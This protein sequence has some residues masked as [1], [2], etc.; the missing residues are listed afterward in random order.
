MPPVLPIMRNNVVDVYPSIHLFSLITTRLSGSRKRRYAFLLAMVLNCEI[1]VVIYTSFRVLENE[2]YR[3]YP[4][5]AK[6]QTLF[7]PALALWQLN[8]DFLF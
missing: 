3:K 5:D 1:R 4:S 6:R 2:K 8:I 7:D